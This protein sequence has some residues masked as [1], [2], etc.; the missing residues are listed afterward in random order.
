M[1]GLGIALVG[2]GFIADYHLDGLSV[3]AEAEVRVIASRTVTKAQDVAARHGVA[4]ATDDIGAAICRPDVAA[5]VITTPDDTHEALACEA[6]RAGRAVLLQKPMAPTAAA[7]RRILAVAAETGADLQ[8]S[9]MHRHFEEVAAAQALLANDAIGR[10]TSVRIRNATPGP[11]WGD[12]FFRRDVVGGGVVLQLGIHGIDLV[13]YLF[14]PIVA[15]SARTATLLKERRLRDGRVICVEN[16]D[17]AH[18]VYELEAGP[19]VAHEMSMIE[20]AGTDRF[21]MEIYG[22]DGVLWLRTEHGPLAL[23]RK[24]ADSWTACPVP[25][26]PLGYRHHRAWVD[27]LLGGTKQASA[28]DGLRSMLVA[29]AIAASAERGGARMQV[30]PT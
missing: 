5:V 24:G 3:V 18:A 13:S 8:V 7:C 25:V 23:R 1:N 6:M 12:W 16:P 29:E 26:A 17:T 28:N 20:P 27:S 9:W 11:D 2:A 21:R 14:G 4:D 30:E 19:L 10:V 22:T 15:V